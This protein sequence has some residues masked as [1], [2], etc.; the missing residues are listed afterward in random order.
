[1]QGSYSNQ[2]Y[3]QGQHQQAQYGNYAGGWP[4]AQSPIHPGEMAASPA[5]GAWPEM[6]QMHSGG[7]TPAWAAGGH[8]NPYVSPYMMPTPNLP[9]GLQ[10][11]GGGEQQHSLSYPAPGAGAG[12]AQNRMSR[13][14]NSSVNRSQTMP[15]PR[16]TSGPLKSALRRGHPSGHN[17]IGSLTAVPST[18]T[19]ADL[20]L[21]AS[22]NGLG[23]GGM[24]NSI[25][26]TNSRPRYD[27]S[28]HSLPGISRQNSNSPLDAP[29]QSS[30]PDPGA[31]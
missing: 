22:T 20:A 17:R 5:G 3:S 14:K 1:M 4:H 18:A 15:Q 25:S 16:S 10:L 24:P 19:A 27:H 21:T 2:G 12:S 30:L 7:N 6:S 31:P 23:P 13:P 29:G 11:P 9:P 28:H 8:G 26:R